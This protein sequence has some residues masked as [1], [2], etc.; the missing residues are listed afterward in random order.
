MANRVLYRPCGMKTDSAGKI[1]HLEM[2]E[3]G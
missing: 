3:L 2:D 1:I